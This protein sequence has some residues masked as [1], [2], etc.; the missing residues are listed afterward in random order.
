M[1]TEDRVKFSSTE[2]NTN[3]YKFKVEM[4]VSIFAEN[5]FQAS[6]QL[7]TNGGFVISRHVELLDTK[8]IH[9]AKENEK[10]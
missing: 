3:A 4:V 7:D 8:K 9:G 6:E 5:E 1:S 2:Q 10:E